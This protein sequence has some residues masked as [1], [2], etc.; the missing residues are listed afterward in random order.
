MALMFYCELTLNGT[1]L[2]GD[3]T[4]N[5]IGGVDVS[6]DHIEG[7]EL[8]FGTR[9][10]TMHGGSGRSGKRTMDPVRIC[11]AIDRTT[12]LLYQGLAQNQIID[13]DIKLFDMD[14]TDGTTR[15]RFTLRLSRARISAVTSTSPDT[16]S[17]EQAN[18]PAYEWLE[19][20]PHS[21]AYI[22]EVNS[23][24]FEDSITTR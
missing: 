1:A 2:T 24:E 12:P 8:H 11:K 3:V 22:D 17:A 9:M 7:Y 10:D 19:L 20:A 13:G 6:A 23:V 4:M 14:P 16:F 5:T 15:H 18:R 21:I